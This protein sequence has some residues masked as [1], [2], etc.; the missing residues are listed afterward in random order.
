MRNK[1]FY[2]IF[3]DKDI[4][5]KQKYD[6]GKTNSFDFLNINTDCSYVF[7]TSEKKAMILIFLTN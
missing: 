1:R 4:T 2:L 3:L 6:D 5:F 7:N